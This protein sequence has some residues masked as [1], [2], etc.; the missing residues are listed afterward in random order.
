MRL[1]PLRLAKA[2]IGQAIALS[3][4]LSDE[5]RAELRA[6]VPGC[7]MEDAVVSSMYSSKEAWII[8]KNGL[9]LAIFGVTEKGSP[10]M[11]A[12][13]KKAFSQ[14]D[15]A[16]LIRHCR[17]AVERWQQV[18]PRLSYR[19]HAD[20]AHHHKLLRLLGFTIGEPYDW[21]GVPTV[22]FWKENFPCAA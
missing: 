1:L 22:D 15:T 5:D 11:L 8:E 4:V 6:Y 14:R 17:H 16:F 13:H 19:A 10:W 18:H 7:S 21:N 2:T 12:T 9:P 20:S 3:R